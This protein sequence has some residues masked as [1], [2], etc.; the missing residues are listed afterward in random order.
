MALA[1]EFKSGMVNL[2][3][4]RVKKNN[5]EVKK[6][7]SFEFPEFWIDAT[8]I[9]EMDTLVLLFEQVF[10]DLGFKE[11]TT[12]ISINN[13]SIIYRE[14]IVPKIDDKKL[15]LLVRSEMMDVLNLTSDYIMDF[16]VLDEVEVDGAASYRLLAVASLS[17]ALESY[18]SLMKRLKLKLVSIDS[19]TNS[20]I[21]TVSMSPSIIEK[22]QVILVDIG[23]GH[24]RLYLFE[25]GQYVLSRNTRLVNLSESSKEEVIATIEDNINKMIQFSYTRGTK[26]GIKSI[27]LVGQDEILAELKKR[28]SEDLF[29]PCDVL[30]CP[31][32]VTWDQPFQSKYINAIGALVRKG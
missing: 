30:E 4:A 16:I 15:P 8:G 32:F 22:E 6:A 2:V 21:K 19:A 28:V 18:M 29:V 27:V 5:I 14:L 17:S 13:S 31:S 25:L 10:E 12:Y 26:G 3:E 9:Q 7:H 23:S 1:I 11:K 24:L 20:I